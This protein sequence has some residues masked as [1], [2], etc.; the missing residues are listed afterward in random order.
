MVYGPAGRVA[1]PVM[2]SEDLTRFS[3]VSDPNLHPDGIRVAFVVSALNFE[4]DRLFPMTGND[5][6]HKSPNRQSY[7]G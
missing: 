2:R 5:L 1:L 7:I 4:D 6:Q 3:T